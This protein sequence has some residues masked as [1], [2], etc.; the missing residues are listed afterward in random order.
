[1]AYFTVSVQEGQ[2]SKNYVVSSKKECFPCTTEELSRRGLSVSRLPPEGMQ[3]RWDQRQLSI[4]LQGAD[5]FSLA[6]LQNFINVKLREYVELSDERHFHCLSLWIIATYYF[7]LFPAFPYLHITGEYQSGKTKVLQM[8]ALLSFNG[9]LLTSTSSPASVIRL[10]HANGTTCCLDEVEHL[11][12]AQDEHSRSLQDV[13]RSGYKRGVSVFKCEPGKKKGQFDVVNYDP[14]SPK[15]LGGIE[16]LE[17]ALASRCIQIVMLRSTNDVLLN[18]EVE[19][20]SNEW[21]DLRA[22]LYPTALCSYPAVEEARRSL[23]VTD[24]I[25]REAELWRPLLTI[26][27]ATGSQSLIDTI[28]ALAKEVRDV[29]RSEDADSETQK[30]LPC[31]YGMLEGAENAILPVADINEKLKRL[32]LCTKH[33]QTKHI[34]GKKKRCYEIKMSSVQEAAK[35]Y[36]TSLIS[37]EPVT[38]VTTEGEEPP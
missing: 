6:D 8:L 27:K 33:S 15:A 12:N 38:S 20:E 9:E 3:R 24:V 1:M 30:I 25:G 23:Q 31:L 28:I 36:S 2:E 18:K 11:W 34:E 4:F 5:V 22:L 19:I 21:S 37:P 17:Q 26:A 10:V 13:L 16:R 35:R 7:R 14:Y 32:G 29:R